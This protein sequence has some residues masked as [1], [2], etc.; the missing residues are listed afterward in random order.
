M[1]LVLPEDPNKIVERINKAIQVLGR[2]RVRVQR[3]TASHTQK[4][5]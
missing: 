2:D 5:L 1:Y 4:S 3:L